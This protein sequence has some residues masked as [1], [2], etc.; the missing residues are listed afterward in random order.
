MSAPPCQ[1]E[2]VEPLCPLGGQSRG[3]SRGWE[4]PQSSHPVAWLGRHIH[5]GSPHPLS[6]SLFT[7]VLWGGQALACLSADLEGGLG[8]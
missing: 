5:S 4:P 6:H 2:W 7:T 8:Q 3:G 1:G